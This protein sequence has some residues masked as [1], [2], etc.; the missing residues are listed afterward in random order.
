MGHSAGNDMNF[1]YDSVDKTDLLDAIDKIWVY[2]ESVD[3]GHKKSS[4]N[5]EH[6]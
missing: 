1:R 4:Q 3:Q 6:L 5:R 2:L